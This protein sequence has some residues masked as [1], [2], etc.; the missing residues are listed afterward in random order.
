[1]NPP[2]EGF[3]S[4]LNVSL[5]QEYLLLAGAVLMLIGGL[6]LMV[7]VLGQIH[8]KQA[9]PPLLMQL[10]GILAVAGAFGAVRVQL[11]LDEKQL[12]MLV[13]G[14]L[15]GGVVLVLLGGLWLIVRIFRQIEWKRVW[16]PF[17]FVF[18]GAT[19]AGVAFG[20][21]W[22][23]PV[24]DF[25]PHERIVDGER[26]LTLTGWNRNDYSMLTSRP[27]TVVL[28]MANPDVDDQTLTYVK[29]MKQLRKLDVA[30][31]AITDAGLASLEELP[32]L[33]ELYLQNT[34][35]TDSGFSEHLAKIESLRR[36]DLSGTQVSKEVVAEW[37]K[38]VP[39]RR[40]LQ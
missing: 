24:I 40:V 22:V 19:L 10:L 31:S 12:R 34:K 38:A 3:L 27:D 23:A 11:G 17:C 30:N 21:N 39:G 7:R 25:G 9:I 32:A 26:H 2:T 6:W 16:L 1:M 4:S 37:K 33:Q 20:L 8:W 5:V 28:Q 14:L 18:L 13:L 35:I 29:D 15:G 36:L